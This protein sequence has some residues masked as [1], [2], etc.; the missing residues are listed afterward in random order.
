MSTGIFELAHLLFAE[1]CLMNID[2]LDFD[3]IDYIK[4]RLDV[5]IDPKD[6][7]Q[8]GENW[9]FMS[10][11]AQTWGDLNHSAADFFDGLQSLRRE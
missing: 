6:H 1:Y 2:G 11:R 5:A 8:Y 9:E 10:S 3:I 7:S 4:I